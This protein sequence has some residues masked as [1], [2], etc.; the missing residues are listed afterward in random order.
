MNVL[1]V[2][3]PGRGR[4]W[5][6]SVGRWAVIGAVAWAITSLSL[7]VWIPPHGDDW[8]IDLVAG[9]L[10]GLVAGPLSGLSA[11][12]ALTTLR[13]QIA[14]STQAVRCTAAA[15]TAAPAVLLAC[16]VS[17]GG[18]TQ[19]WAMLWA[20]LLVLVTAGLGYLTGPRVFYGKLS[21]ASWPV[22]LAEVSVAVDLGDAGRA[23]RAADDVDTASLSAERQGRMLIDVARAHAQ[24][25][26]VSQAV[27]ALRQAEDLTPEQVRGHNLARQIVSDLLTMQDPPTDDLRALA[28]RLGAT[29]TRD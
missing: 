14:G 26:Q 1:V 20:V 19:Q 12:L 29:R 6:R 24:R 8:L 23:L 10:L 27:A 25:R 22:A 9:A 28:A 13:K 11:G 21:C 17:I 18:M 4:I 16:L 7:G 5:A 15:G 3:A 2:V